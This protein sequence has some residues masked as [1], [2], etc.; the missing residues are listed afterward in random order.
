[1]EIKTCSLTENEIQ[2]LI[3]HHGRC[4]DHSDFQDRIERI[5]YLNRRLK[6]EKKEVETKPEPTTFTPTPQNPTVKSE[7]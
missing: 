2:V 7:W 3:S 5:T 4:L 1:M 6:A